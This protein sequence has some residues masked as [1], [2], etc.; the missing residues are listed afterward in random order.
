MACVIIKAQT[1]NFKLLKPSFQPKN[2]S[3]LPV[4][5]K[6]M[7]TNV[8][9]LPFKL[10][11]LATNVRLL[12]FKL[13][14]LIANVRLLPFKL[15]RLI[16]NVRLLPF[17]LKR[18]ITN[19]RLLPF[20]LKRLITNI[21]LPSFK[22]KR[23]ATNVHII[24]EETR[25]MQSEKA[26]YLFKLKDYQASPTLHLDESCLKALKERCAYCLLCFHLRWVQSQY[27]GAARMISSLRLYMVR[28]IWPS[29]VCC[30]VSVMSS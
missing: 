3:C 26:E 8:R 7:A 6:R 13:K 25:L 17:K 22:L 9:L 30:G 29:V 15:K 4:K 1:L 11:R 2:I 18:L 20:K 5:L 19:V 12:P 28:V 23:M 27:W 16:T 21:R 10:K 14:R 24:A